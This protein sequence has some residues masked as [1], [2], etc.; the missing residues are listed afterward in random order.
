VEAKRRLEK[1]RK[2][3]GNIRMAVSCNRDGRVLNGPIICG[4][5]EAKYV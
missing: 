1:A 4:A 5:M 2:H 3:R